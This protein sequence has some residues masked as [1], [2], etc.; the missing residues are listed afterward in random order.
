MDKVL[1][2]LTFTPQKTSPSKWSFMHALVPQQAVCVCV[3]G[4]RRFA[5]YHQIEHIPSNLS[6]AMGTGNGVNPVFQGT[7]GCILVL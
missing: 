5:S 3:G 2:R 1:T 6:T 7:E 4:G